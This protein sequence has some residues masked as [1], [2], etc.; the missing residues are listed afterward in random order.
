MRRRSIGKSK[1]HKLAAACSAQYEQE[2]PPPA[3]DQNSYR[4]QGY[5][6]SKI[7]TDEE[8]Q[9]R[10]VIPR[11][12][13]ERTQDEISSL[14]QQKRKNQLTQPRQAFR[15]T[16]FFQQIGQ[17]PPKPNRSQVPGKSNPNSKCKPL[18]GP[19]FAKVAAGPPRT[20]QRSNR[21][22]A[23]DTTWIPHVVDE[24]LDDET[25]DKEINVPMR[26]THQMKDKEGNITEGTI[27]VSRTILPPGMHSETHEVAYGFLDKDMVLHQ[28]IHYFKITKPLPPTIKFRQ[29]I[30]G[31]NLLSYSVLM[32]SP[33]IKFE[34]V[35][36]YQIPL[37]KDL[38]GIRDWDGFW[39]DS[40]FFVDLY[41]DDNARMDETTLFPK[42][43]VPDSPLW[44]ME[45]RGSY[46]SNSIL[47]HCTKSA[48]GNTLKKLN[49]H[50]NRGFEIKIWFYKKED[51]QT[52]LT[53]SSYED[54]QESHNMD[55]N[56]NSVVCALETRDNWSLFLL[57]YFAFPLFSKA[58][59]AK[60]WRNNREFL[61]TLIHVRVEDGSAETEFQPYAEPRTIQEICFNMLRHG[62]LV[63]DKLNTITTI[64]EKD[65]CKLIG[66]FSLSSIYEVDSEVMRRKVIDPKKD[67]N[68]AKYWENY[69]YF[70]E[71]FDN[72]FMPI[73]QANYKTSKL[74]TLLA[75][76][77]SIWKN[78]EKPETMQETMINS[79]KDKE[80]FVNNDRYGNEIASMQAVIHHNKRQREN[81]INRQVEMH[82]SPEFLEKLGESP[83]KN[84]KVNKKLGEKANYK[85]AKIAEQMHILG[86]NEAKEALKI[87]ELE[88]TIL[89]LK[90]DKE[91]LGKKL[92]TQQERIEQNNAALEQMKDEFARIRG[93]M[94]N[95][96]QE[97]DSDTMTEEPSVD[98]EP[99]R[100]KRTLR[101]TVPS[102]PRPPT[103]HN[104]AFSKPQ[105]TRRNPKDIA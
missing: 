46:W 4:R 23:K 60:R 95:N 39:A 83:E 14:S 7:T 101:G 34:E 104:P 52:I 103:G 93:E 85:E 40:Q 29:P 70:A 79:L 80:D 68:Y 20:N 2:E 30:P 58:E 24:A 27:Y 76:P 56:D 87:T 48:L 32:H 102:A 15:T 5:D 35:L 98:G 65:R 12:V 16:T 13:F 43:V 3:T 84:Q 99:N 88:K 38:L 42:L 67:S 19:S 55:P 6:Q 51:P 71:A 100:K 78:P 96:R 47:M 26:T 36:K 8:Y 66:A 22:V 97:P 89:N 18:I 49:L 53:W 94:Q 86:T 33:N 81:E 50:I 61:S 75:D 10:M 1:A 28:G 77:N 25:E 63:H 59:P 91:S 73:R 11:N 45:L 92:L 72:N 74:H 37:P 54:E 41:G 44:P 31:Q 105:G 9:S 62:F 69:Q 57:Y 17:E 82:S 64:Q 90:E 21:V